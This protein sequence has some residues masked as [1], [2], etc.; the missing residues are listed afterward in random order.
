MFNEVKE[1]SL[2]KGNV[3]NLFL[4][5]PLLPLYKK[6]TQTEKPRTYLLYTTTRLIFVLSKKTNC[7]V[8]KDLHLYILLCFQFYRLACDT[9][10]G[11]VPTLHPPKY[12]ADVMYSNSMQYWHNQIY[13]VDFIVVWQVC[14]HVVSILW[15]SDL[16]HDIDIGSPWY[17][18]FKQS[19]R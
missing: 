18:L 8:D 1:E 19:A 11:Q 10:N 17:K 7:I 16:Q 14:H 2:S 13:I 4:T 9:C 12:Q 5:S 6:R 3:Y 15:K